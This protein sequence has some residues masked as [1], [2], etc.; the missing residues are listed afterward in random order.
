MKTPDGYDRVIIVFEL[1]RWRFE[2][3]SIPALRPC[4]HTHRL[5]STVFEGVLGNFQRYIYVPG[6][7]LTPILYPTHEK[8]LKTRL[9]SILTFGNNDRKGESVC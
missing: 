8:H 9:L 4:S 5:H 6:G 3:S 7:S 1:T 2:P